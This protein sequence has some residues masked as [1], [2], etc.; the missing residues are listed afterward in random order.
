[1]KK[2]KW[3]WNQWRPIGRMGANNPT[4]Q[5]I[6]PVLRDKK[7]KGMAVFYPPKC[8]GRYETNGTWYG[9]VTH[10]RPK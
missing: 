8:G 1:M 4:E 5:G 6:Y 2:K 9:T 3:R 7:Y 10:W